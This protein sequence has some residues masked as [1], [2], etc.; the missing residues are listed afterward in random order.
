MHFYHQKLLELEDQSDEINKEL[1]SKVESL[2]AILRMLELRSKNGADHGE[3]LNCWDL[4]AEYVVPQMPYLLVFLVSR[5]EEKENEMKKEYSKLHDRYTELFKTHM[6]YM[7][8]TKIL[9]G[10]GTT[11]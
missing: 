5:L 9:M 10:T 1:S 11:N 7:E 8:R 4:V 6:D 2:E 3:Y